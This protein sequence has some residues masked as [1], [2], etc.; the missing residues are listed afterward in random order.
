M[1]KENKRLTTVL[2][3]RGWTSRDALKTVLMEDP[4]A[5]DTINRLATLT[6]RQIKAVLPIGEGLTELVKRN[7]AAGADL[8]GAID[9]ASRRDAEG[10]SMER[11]PREDDCGDTFGGGAGASASGLLMSRNL[12]Q[13]PVAHAVDMITLQAVK[14][15]APDVHSCPEPPQRNGTPPTGSSRPAGSPAGARYQGRWATSGKTETPIFLNRSEIPIQKN[16]KTAGDGSNMF[17]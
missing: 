9:N 13:A 15:E 11:V 5:S 3:E 17:G 4:G 16:S 6:G 10:T 12:N 7:Y 1:M 2:Q 8:T 14:I